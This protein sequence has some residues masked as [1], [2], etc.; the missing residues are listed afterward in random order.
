MDNKHEDRRS[1]QNVSNHILLTF[2]LVCFWITILSTFLYAFSWDPPPPIPTDDPRWEKVRNLWNNHYGGDNLDELINTLFLLKGAYPSKIEP[3]I[4]LAKAHYLHARYKKEDRREH[5]EKAEE[6]A[7]KACKMDPK[8]LYALTTLI[9]TICYSRDH[10]YIF[11]KYGPLIRSHAPIKDTAEALPDMQYP[12][13]N[14]FKTLWLARLDVEKAKSAVA[15]VEK[16]SKEHPADG[17]AQTWASR[18]NYYIGQYYTSINKH[19][20]GMTYYKK[21]IAYG[22]KAREILPHSVPANYWYMLNLARSIQFTSFAHKAF[23]LKNILN[24]IYFCSKENSIYFFCGP[25]ISLATIVTNGGWI[26]EKGMSLVNI[27][28]EMDLNGLEIASILFPHYYY[29]SYAWADV[30]AYKGKPAEALAILEKLIA[31]DPNIDPLIPE[32]HC[33]IRLAKRLYND[34]KQGKY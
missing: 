20:E 11:G 22:T 27:T 17:L 29:I 12:G 4:L 6:Y 1:E 13:W 19:N 31:S 14:S 24:P 18:A 26:T 33:F 5:F 9:E 16:M 2:F 34:I 7:S 32:N 30:L 28:M 21:G 15:M 25:V 8:N 23:Y 10:D 3:I